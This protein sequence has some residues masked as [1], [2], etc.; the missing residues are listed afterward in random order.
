MDNKSFVDV[1]L[2][3]KKQHIFSSVAAKHMI[4]KL[5]WRDLKF[6]LNNDISLF[7]V[8]RHS[9]YLGHICHSGLVGNA[10]T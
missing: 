10:L 4:P 7:R 8:S 6:G 9:L 2:C 1:V 3:N 5:K